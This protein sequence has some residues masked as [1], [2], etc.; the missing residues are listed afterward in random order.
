MDRVHW[1][2]IGEEQ[3]GAA[4]HELILMCPYYH[5][6]ICAALSQSARILIWLCPRL[7]IQCVPTIALVCVGS[8]DWR[9]YVNICEID[10]N[11]LS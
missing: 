11:L 4:R 6:G 1:V 10:V 9:R 2:S 5:Y 3:S 8:G 7:S